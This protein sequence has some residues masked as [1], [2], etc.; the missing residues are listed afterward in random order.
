MLGH[1]GQGRGLHHPQQRLQ[2]R[3]ACDLERQVRVV[4]IGNARLDAVHAQ[5]AL[6]LEAG[7]RLLHHHAVALEHQRAAQV[8]QHR[9]RK[10]A[11]AQQ[12]LRGEVVDHVAHRRLDV[13]APAARL[14][15]RH[16]VQV[17]AHLELH[18][19]ALALA[20]AVAHIVARQLRHLQR[21]VA[22]HARAVGPLQLPGQLQVAGQAVFR[23][24]AHA[25]AALRLA[26][27]IGIGK[28][29]GG[30][31]Q[32]EVATV[33]PP[34]HL[35]LQRVHRDRRLL[36]HP[37]EVQ[38]PGLQIQTGLA[39]ALVQLKGGIQALDPGQS[40]P[41]LGRLRL[42][43]QAADTPARLV[44]GGRDPLQLQLPHGAFGLPALQRGQHLGRHRQ[45]L[46][47]LRGHGDVGIVQGHLGARLCR[48]PRGAHLPVAAGPVLAIHLDK[49]EI[50]A[51]QPPGLLLPVGLQ[52]AVQL[53][54]LQG[55]YLAV[56]PLD[57][58][59]GQGHVGRH[60]HRLPAG[61]I[62]PDAHR[63]AGLD[64]LDAPG[65]GPGQGRYLAHLQGGIPLAIPAL[66]RGQGR[67]QQRL[68]EFAHHLHALALACH[69][70]GVHAQHVVPVAVA[71][72]HLHIA[73]LRG[74]GGL[75]FIG[76]LHHPTLDHQLRLLQQP[77][78]GP[79]VLRGVAGHH[80]QAR[81]L[82]A[83]VLQVAHVQ[84]GGVDIQLLQP[85]A[86]HRARRHRHHHALQLQ[87][88]ALLRV[89]DGHTGQLDGRE[90]AFR[91]R[92]EGINA[93]R[94]PQGLRRQ[95]LHL[96]APLPN[97]RHNESVQSPPY[98]HQHQPE[99]Q[100]QS[101]GPTRHAGHEM[102]LS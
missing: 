98:A 64:R 35:R 26:L 32:P 77:L 73:P 53:L 42:D 56:A 101:Q 5:G 81:D 30:H 90:Q 46:D 28:A 87:R 62:D 99:R 59:L 70:G 86:Q 34:A 67:R 88:L 92:R 44:V 49:A 55:R 47:H 43:H 18:L 39:T 72:H 61:H 82:P 79:V 97:S 84:L 50:L 45:G 68:A 91:A 19:A 60:A 71:H 10:V 11:G 95:T 22:V 6:A 37:G 1:G 31:I 13:E 75:L 96:H 3:L 9:P 89:Q 48:R 7:A 16:V 24:L 76:E 66:P 38:H 25:P 52:P 100:H 20:H 58:G 65:L 23:C 15:E 14:L 80:V 94:S 78:Q 93:H 29:E 40:G 54:Q 83:P 12:P 41:V 27:G 17:A 8:L 4:Q 57:L 63:A 2:R 33:H 102:Q 74:L 21:Q 51:G 36:E 69:G 85:Q